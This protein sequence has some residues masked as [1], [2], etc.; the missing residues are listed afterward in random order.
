MVSQDFLNN[1]LAIL[2]LNKLQTTV[3]R[4]GF[5]LGQEALAIL[6]ELL[7]EVHGAANAK[8]SPTPCESVVESDQHGGASWRPNPPNVVAACTQVILVVEG[9]VVDR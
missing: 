1:G 2:D 9:R 7:K 4:S 8:S 5:P 3:E 6:R